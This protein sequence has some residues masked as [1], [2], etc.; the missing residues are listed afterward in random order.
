[1]KLL[2]KLGTLFVNFCQ[3]DITVAELAAL[4]WPK[5]PFSKR[6]D[7]KLQSWHLCIVTVGLESLN[8]RQ[9]YGIDL[10]SIDLGSILYRSISLT[11]FEGQPLAAVIPENGHCNYSARSSYAFLFTFFC[12]LKKAQWTKSMFKKFC[13]K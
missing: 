1:M 3:E 5:K 2:Y 13:G 4:Y 12:T 6:L 10:E 8:S 7:N 11:I 9:K